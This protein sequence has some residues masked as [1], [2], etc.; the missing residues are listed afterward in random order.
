MVGYLTIG[1]CSYNDFHF[2]LSIFLDAKKYEDATP[3]GTHGQRETKGSKRNEATF[4]YQ[5]LTRVTYS[6][7]PNPC[8]S[9][10]NYG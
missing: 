6:T 1:I 4:L 9:T 10:R 5:H 3:N 7:H 8:S 2:H